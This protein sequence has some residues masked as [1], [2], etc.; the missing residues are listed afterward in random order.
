M[1]GKKFVGAAGLGQYLH[2]N[3]RVPA[4]LVRKLYAYGAGANSEE[5]ETSA[6]R[7][8]L[9]RFT[10]AGYRLQPL[11][12]AMVTSPQFFSAPPPAAAASRVSMNAK[13]GQ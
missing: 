2:D 13:K 10:V 3:P 6:V 7:P 8:Y 1:S 5:V 9:D 12:E 11:L 4:C